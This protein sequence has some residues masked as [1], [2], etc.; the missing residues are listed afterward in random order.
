MMKRL[1]SKNYPSSNSRKETVND[2]NSFSVTKNRNSFS[3]N[4]SLNPTSMDNFYNS[5]G[6]S[7]PTRTEPVEVRVYREIPKGSSPSFFKSLA[8]TLAMLVV[9]IGCV[10]GQTE[11]PATATNTNGPTN[12]STTGS[13]VVP[14]NVTQIEVRAWGGGGAGAGTNN[15]GAG[16]LAGGAGGS[17]A[18]STID[19]T[20]GQLIYYSV[21]GTIAGSNTQLNGRDTWLNKSSSAAPSSSTNGVV[22]KGGQGASLTT[23]GAGSTTGCVGSTLFRGGSG[24]VGGAA[25]GGGGSGAG[26]SQNGVD[27]TSSTGA[28]GGG[29]DGGAG[30]ASGGNGGAG[31][32]PGGGGGGAF[33]NDNTNRTGG[34]GGA[35]RIRLIYTKD[36]CSNIIPL[37]SNI[38]SSYTLYATTGA[39]DLATTPGNEQIFSFVPSTSGNHI[40]TLTSNSTDVKLLYKTGSCDGTGWTESIQVSTSGNT[41][42]NLVAGTTYYFVVDDVVSTSQS[43]GTILVSTPSHCTPSGATNYWL[44]NV[45]TTGGQTNISNSTGASAGGYINYSSTISCS[46]YIGATTSITLTPSSGTN[47]FYCWIDWNNDLD[48]GDANETV[49]ATTSY[50]SNHTETITIPA[51]TANGNYRMR[52]A[53][54]WSGAITSCGP[55]SNG[56]YEDYTFSVVSAPACSDLPSS[57]ISSNVATTTA[58]LSWNAASPAPGSGYDIYYSASST[59]P[60]AGTAATT[61]TTAGVVT[62]NITGLTANTT[63]YWWVRSNCNGT[64]KSNWVSGGTFFTGYCTPAPSSVDGSGITNVSF[65][66]DPI[67]NNPTGAE[68]GNYGDFSS[69]IGAGQQGQILNVD[70]TYSTGYTYDTKIWV[71]WNNN[72]S[73]LDAGEE[74]YVGTS[75]SA[76]PTILSAS[77]TIPLSTPIGNYRMRIGGQDAGPATPCYTSTYGSFEDYTLQVLVAPAC[78]SQPSALTSSAI[79]TSTATISW[80]AASS[81]PANGYEYY[82]ST[83]SSAPTAGTAATGSTAAGVVSANLSSLSSSTTYYFWVRS[84]CNGT[85]KSNWVGSATFTTP[86]EAISTFP[87]T[88]TFSDNSTTRSCWTVRD[89]NADSYFWQISSSYPFDAGGNHASLYTDL[90]SS[91]QDYLITPQ[92]NLG[93]TGRQLKFQIR[94]YSN[95]E[96]DNIR[97]KLSTTGND[98]AN[99]TTSLLTLSTTQITTTYTEYSVNLSSYSGNV[100]IAFV[101]EDAPANGWYVYIDEVK[102]VNLPTSVPTCATYIFPT[103][104]E[105]VVPSSGSVPVSWNA[106]ADADSYDVYKNGSFVANTTSTSYSLTGNT[107]GN[108]YTWYVVPKNSVGNA[109]GCSGGAYSFTCISTPSN[110][111]PCGAI[112]L[113]ISN[114][115]TYATYSNAGATA[116]SGPPAP[117]CALYSTADVWFSVTVPASGIINF[118]SQTGTITDAGMAIY[119]GTCSSLTLVEC[120]DDDSPNGAM[121]YISLTGRTPGETL[122]IRMWEYGGDVTGTFGLCVRSQAA[123]LTSATLNQNNV[124]PGTSVTLTA[125]G[126]DGTAYWFTTCGTSG[127]LG[128]GG[129]LNVSPSTTTTYYARNY[130]Y[131]NFSTNCAT[132]TVTVTQPSTT[133]SVNNTNI[134]NGDYLWS[135]N[136]STDGSDASNWYVF[137]GTNY[138]VATSAPTTQNVYIVSNTAATNCVSANSNPPSINPAAGTFA[139]SNV[140]IGSGLT[141]T[142]ANGSTFNVTGN[143]IN[144]GTF[145]PGTGTVNMNGSTAQTIGGSAAT[146]FNN[147]TINN[148]AGVS[149]NRALDVNGT[150]NLSNGVLSLGNNNLTLGTGGTIS[151]SSPSSSKMINTSGSGELRK[152][153]ATAAGTDPAG[154]LFPVGTTGKYTPVLLDFSNVTFGSDAYMRV[155]VEPNKSSFLSPN[156]T[157]YL[158]RNWIVEPN[159]I[160]NYTYAINLQYAEGDF[161]S[162]G[163]EDDNIVPIKY[164][165]GQW[166][167]PSGLLQPFPNATN[168]SGNYFASGTS[169]TNNALQ[170]TRVFGWSGLQTFSEFGG[171]GQTGQPLPVELVSFS[172]LCEEGIINLTWQTASEFNSSHFD[173]EKSRDGENWQV[174]TTLPSAGTS[175]ELITYQTTDQNATDGNNYFRLRQVDIDGQEKLYNPINVSCSEVTTGYFSSFPNPSGSAFQVIVNNKELVGVCNMNIVD[176]SGKVIETRSIEVKDGINMFV[177]NQELTPGIYFLNVTNGTKSTPVLRHAIK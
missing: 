31:G 129:T 16:G 90:S 56:E 131:G 20:P 119:S 169:S 11:L 68:S 94:H 126:V 175:N 60:V 23:A 155:R 3:Q 34:N 137:N 44:S 70:I 25:S 144:N 141:L 173:V 17:Y 171:A 165:N 24:R 35:G 159:D 95:S 52:V 69:Q 51:G 54:S 13:W 73:F 43:S 72:L 150:L 74:M 133:I 39:W 41:T 36:P 9:G 117:G 82:L 143:F 99:F 38:S 98:I 71:D 66:L 114:T 100:Y 156:L 97:V 108:S 59:A 21:G 80:T 109:S 160:S 81:A 32:N 153:Y 102:I 22:A 121:S 110:D 15:N 107:V 104:G 116:S 26:F 174:L 2:F 148:T 103:N 166:N 161:V 132:V 7:S 177:I 86:C 127:E 63:Y 172:G 140:Y 55:S 76:N 27:A 53:N 147:L 48:F 4:P 151:V 65:G 18:A 152:R 77:F 167:Q 158:N 122:W 157:S 78:A 30:N 5:T 19:V 163:I 50:T 145:T 75:T 12:N 1:D 45:V 154:F 106:I 62:K 112:A 164:S 79:T 37:T 120:D 58:T 134:A 83:S 57:L 149:L 124:C 130:R 123:D 61:T 168:E 111:D 10:W 29:G 135:G 138:T 84:N 46:N 64:D 47:Y 176:A 87:W 91:N 42:L 93:S 89:G 142:Q 14:N 128:T 101:R 40:I 115:L 146:T 162:G 67:V 85:D 49:F 33:V 136:T 28:I 125:N 8:L 92:I 118:D 96:P 88:E 113:S 105:S 170:S 6:V 139:A